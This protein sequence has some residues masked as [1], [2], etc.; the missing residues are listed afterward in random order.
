[1]DA[2]GLGVHADGGVRR[3][4]ERAHHLVHRALADAG[5]F[6]RAGHDDA[7][8]DQ[9]RQTGRH[10]RFPHAL[11]F[12]RRAGHRNQDARPC[13]PPTSRGPCP[14]G[15]GWHAP[16]AMRAACLTLRSGM[17]RP[18]LAK[19]VRSWASSSGW[20]D[21]GSSSAAAMAS[22]VTSSSVGPRPPVAS[23]RSERSQARRK[24]SS[25]G[26][27]CRPPG[28][29]STDR[30]PGPA[31]WRPGSW[32]WC[33]KL[34]QQ[35][36]ADRDDLGLHEQGQDRRQG[37]KGSRVE[38]SVQG[39]FRPPPKGG[40]IDSPLMPQPSGWGYVVMLVWDDAN[41]SGGLPWERTT[42]DARPFFLLVASSVGLLVFALPL[43][44]SPLRWAQE[45]ALEGAGGY[46]PGGLPG[47]LP[48]RAG[49]RPQR[50]RAA[51][52]PAIPGAI[53]SSSP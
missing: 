25:G 5:R 21:S 7:A 4:E 10:L 35:D 49:H 41:S 27:G 40:G 37:V 36:G 20:T 32:R 11:Q 19:K 47:P 14:A 3:L 44:L 46:R 13:A 2:V 53:V 51:G 22:R 29:S 9:S 18:R 16:D 30:R 50:R 24:A 23:V 42:I 15:W 6:Q 38:G 17:R 28:S 45:A 26:R 34:A 1:M 33:P 39:S 8:P 43:L 48:G 31:G 52:G 12:R